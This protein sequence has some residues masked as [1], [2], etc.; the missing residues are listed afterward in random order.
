V[1]FDW[2]INPSFLIAIAAL[3][4]TQY[5]MHRTSIET[6][7]ELKVKVEAMWHYFMK[8]DNG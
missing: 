6:I 3:I 5:K 8:E 7:T 2:T 4:L 1:Q